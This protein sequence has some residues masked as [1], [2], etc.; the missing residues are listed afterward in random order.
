[1]I[2]KILFLLISFLYLPLMSQS[3]ISFEGTKYNVGDTIIFGY[4]SIPKTGIY[5]YVK[6]YNYNN[7]RYFGLTIDNIGKYAIILDIIKNDNNIF[8]N[9]TDSILVVGKKGWKGFKL[10]VNINEAV[11]SG[12]VI[13][14]YD[15]N[16]KPDITTPLMND[17]VTF[18]LNVL[19]NKVDLDKNLTDSYLR[20]FDKEY[21]NYANDEFALN[22]NLSETKPKIIS[23]IN[24]YD[25]T[26]KY[27]IN[28]KATLS[29]Y[30]F[31]ENSFNITYYPN[32]EFELGGFFIGLN[33]HSRIL[34]FI[35]I[36]EFQKIKINPTI[37]N[38]FIKRRKNVYGKVNREVFLKIFI[39]PIFKEDYITG[40]GFIPVLIEKIELYDFENRQYSLLGVLRSN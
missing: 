14:L 19:V 37:A 35:N 12:E 10:F 17:S 39:K 22:E 15:K 3:I 9:N 25:S 4:K 21:R 34:K 32:D 8:Y 1:M 33:K 23:L 28:H 11:K 18:A 13:S 29:E 40:N 26:S 16:I 6:E 36:K 31:D 5:Q 38:K 27:F 30:N 24:N 7:N 2:K 20:E